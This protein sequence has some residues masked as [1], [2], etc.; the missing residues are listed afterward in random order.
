MT[1]TT[2]YS[3]VTYLRVDNCPHCDAAQPKVEALCKLNGI[4][5]LIRKP[6]LGE[7]QELDIPGFPAIVIDS[8]PK[9]ILAGAEAYT[10]LEKIMPPLCTVMVTAMS[11][12]VEDLAIY[13]KSN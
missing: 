8:D 6:R 3:L 9:V 4:P 11:P 2:L 7:V 10:L 13:L 5:L 1:T 12:T